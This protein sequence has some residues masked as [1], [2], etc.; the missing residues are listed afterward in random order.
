MDANIT[1]LLDRCGLVGKDGDTHQGI[2]DEAYLKSIPNTHVWMP[3]N[4]KE[5]E[6]LFHQS[7]KQKGVTA[8]RITCEDAI[9]E[10]V[11]YKNPLEIGRFHFYGLTSAKETILLCVG[12]KAN[13]MAE[14][15]R[16]S[17]MDIEIACPLFLN[18][19]NIEE[20]DRLLPY[21][22]IFIY[23]AYG[24]KEGFC[25]SIFSDLMEKGYQGKVKSFCV[26]NSFIPFSPTR[27]EQEK[28]LQL[29]PDQ[30]LEQILG[31]VKHG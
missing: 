25:S 12:P 19:Y 20:I 26:P 10:P 31:S 14:K 11:D 16:N 8:I 21:K 1:I 24:T 9:P 18:D 7:F 27:G 23:D 2:Y 28:E 6:F 15:I 30:V 22:Q 5:A 4:E 29:D 3:S 17:G 13:T